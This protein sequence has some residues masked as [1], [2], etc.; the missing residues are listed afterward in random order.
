MDYDLT[1]DQGY[2]VVKDRQSGQRYDVA[3]NPRVSNPRGLYT[4]EDLPDNETSADEL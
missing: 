2:D 4:D 3:N 1:E